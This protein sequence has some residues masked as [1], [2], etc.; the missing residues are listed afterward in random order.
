M[1]RVLS[2]AGSDSGGG[3]GIQADLKTFCTFGVYG[4][5]AITAVTAQNTQRVEAIQELPPQIVAAQ[6][7]CLVEDIG[8]DA[9]KTGM[10]SNSEIIEAVASELAR[11]GIEKI[12]V[13]PV[14]V[15][16]SGARLLREE[17]IESLVEKLL[18]LA[19]LVTPNIPEALILAEM[20]KIET[21][22][23]M[24]EA[25]RRIY[26]KGVRAVLVKGGH[27][28]GERTRD[29]LFDGKEFY[30]FEGKRIDT[31]NT[32]GTGCTYSAAIC[33]L[34]ALGYDLSE[35]VKEARK[36]MELVISHSLSLGKGFGPTNHLAPLF[37]K[38]GI[39]PQKGGKLW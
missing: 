13:D 11:Y 20:E 28:P 1:K 34:L 22:A 30:S 14:M 12:V 5:T 6:V 32:H 29:L 21:L 8:V 10:L 2:I 4:M 27:L 36:Y 17:A 19:L 38:E 18:P 15:A 25:A 35:A 23:E 24:Q 39:D 9:V 16:K 37:I 31:K 3:A 33:A 26:Q 7:R